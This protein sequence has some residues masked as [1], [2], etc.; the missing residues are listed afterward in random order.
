M[1]PTTVLTENSMITEACDGPL[2]YDW[3]SKEEIVPEAAPGG[4]YA[5]TYL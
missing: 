5:G 3:D 4:G 1:N 2:I